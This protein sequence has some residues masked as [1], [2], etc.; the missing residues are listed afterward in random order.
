MKSGFAIRYL[1][2]GA[3]ISSALIFSTIQAGLSDPGLHE[4]DCII[5]PLPAVQEI[6][7]ILYQAS[8]LDCP[9][10]S[11]EEPELDEDG[12]KT[13]QLG[14]V[15]IG[16]DIYYEEGRGV[17]W[18][19]YPDSII[20]ACQNL[21][22]RDGWHLEAYQFYEGGNANAKVYALPD[23]SH[24]LP[25]EEAFAEETGEERDGKPRGFWP[26]PPAPDYADGNVMEYFTGD[27]TPR[28]YLEASLLSRELKELGAAWHGV[29]WGV[30]RIINST[31]IVHLGTGE[32]I[33]ADLMDWT[34]TIPTSMEPVICCSETSCSV[35]MYTYTGLYG[36]RI[37]RIADIYKRGTY[38]AS[39]ESNDIATGT[40]GYLF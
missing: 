5:V 9:V 8:S 17:H 6:R 24:L 26:W 31:E 13:R 30:T 35:T 22:I 40:G 19:C 21:S 28:S 32:I 36:E 34:E 7:T 15:D 1:L 37:S 27:D 10:Y 18:I 4:E 14:A 23:G 29:S 12:W 38:S 20:K 2:L 3:F 25:P 33:E 16:S 39:T 11:Q